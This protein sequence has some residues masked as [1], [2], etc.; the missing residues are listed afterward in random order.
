MNLSSAENF[1]SKIVFNTLLYRNLLYE[2][3]SFIL[4]NVPLPVSNEFL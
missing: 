2:K 4:K 1:D 3:V